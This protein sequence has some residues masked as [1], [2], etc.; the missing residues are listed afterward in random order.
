MIKA[1]ASQSPSPRCHQM[2]S[3]SPK[4][5]VRLEKGRAF[6]MAFTQ[7]SAPQHRRKASA[8][9]ASLMALIRVTNASLEL[10]KSALGVPRTRSRDLARPHRA[11][12][13]GEYGSMGRGY[14]RR[15][16]GWSGPKN[17][18]SVMG[19][20]NSERTNAQGGG[21]GPVHGIDVTHGLGNCL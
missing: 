17:T 9:S 6:T 21:I 18:S 8:A 15:C 20:Q 19:V 11:R 2:R 13:T 7:R 12:S 14:A 3:A 10:G 5:S 16:R 4:S 1:A